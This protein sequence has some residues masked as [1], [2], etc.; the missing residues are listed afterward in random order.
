MEYHSHDWHERQCH[1]V[2]EQVVLLSFLCE[3]LPV[4][5]KKKERENTPHV[6]QKLFPGHTRPF[7]GPLRDRV[8]TLCPACSV[9]V[10]VLTHHQS[11]AHVLPVHPVFAGVS[12]IPSATR[13][14]HQSQTQT[15]PKHVKKHHR[16]VFQL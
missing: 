1:P 10:V 6:H 7:A 16:V 11:L 3:H 8:Q 15:Q 14:D 2:S 12:P 13:P 9:D 5:K 4:K